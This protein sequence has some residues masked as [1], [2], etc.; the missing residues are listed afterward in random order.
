MGIMVGALAVIP[1]PASA[2]TPAISSVS[3]GINHTCAV[4]SGGGVKCWG[5][6]YYG[7]LGDGSQTDRLSPVTV[8]GLTSGVRDVAAGEIHS[9]ALT[10]AGGVKCWGYNPWGNI[11]DGTAE[12]WRLTPVDVSGLTSGV[13]A[14]SLRADHTCALTDNGG[15]KCWGSN[16]YGQ[17]GDGTKADR[18]TPV[19]VSGLTSGVA[20]IAAGAGGN[21]CALTTAGGVKCWG[22]NNLHQLGNG[23]TTESL[24]PV[25]VSG[26]TS[27]AAAITVG[28][29]HACALTTGGG[30]KCWG[31]NSYGEVGDGTNTDAPTPVDV[32]GL[33]SGVSAISAG[34]QYTCAL[35][36]LGGVKCWGDN[37]YGQLGDTTTS[38]K[39]SPVDVSGLASGVSAISAG[40]FHVCALT[41]SHELKC[42]GNDDSGQLGDDTI[43]GVSSTPISVR[44][45]LTSV[46]VSD[47]GF[48]WKAVSIEVGSGIRWHFSS[49]ATHTA[50]DAT[51]MGLFDS[52][53]L[54]SRAYFDFFFTGAG[55][56]RYL[57]T[58]HP[59]LTGTVS[60]PAEVSPS[61]GGVSTT[62]TV[63]WAT[64]APASGFVYD[65]Q[66]RRPGATTWK[67]WK[68]SQTILT[69]LFTRHS[70]AGTYSFRARVRKV[71]DATH[72]GWSPAA[73]ISVT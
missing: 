30:V 24:T 68:R 31:L 54:P 57:D 71:A 4:T 45:D 59:T 13:S 1:A 27:G 3:A 62:F 8:S 40:H 43:N 39:P 48:D 42:W 35:M 22:A 12:N 56:F 69:A 32:S 37:R 47:R 33:T 66:I 50:T 16:G 17:L 60:V 61:T 6:N 29:N 15:V 20:A 7:E 46:L 14:I 11:G 19:D 53:V 51:G 2:S 44:W 55:T 21:T 34:A 67:M 18:A 41:D 73:S 38:D 5:A 23:S 72:S 26:L 36:S 70:A 25:D 9:C 58:A 65:V 49:P 63:R 28:A 52:G 64:S 10:T